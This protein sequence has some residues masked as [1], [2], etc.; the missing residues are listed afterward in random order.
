[1]HR[2]FMHILV[3][4]LYAIIKIRSIYRHR[5]DTLSVST[6]S[7]R[8]SPPRL[9]NCTNVINCVTFYEQLA[10]VHLSSLKKVYLTLINITLVPN[11]TKPEAL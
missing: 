4:S 11:G 8:M 2:V 1:M 10:L 5:N 7:R 3:H 6:I 9:I